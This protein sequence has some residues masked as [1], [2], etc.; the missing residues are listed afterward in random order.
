MR[1]KEYSCNR[2]SKSFRKYLLQ[3]IP[4]VIKNKIGIELGIINISVSKDLRYVTIYFMNLIENDDVFY[5]Q[6]I[7]LLKKEIAKSTKMRFIPNIEIKKY[8][9]NFMIAEQNYDD[10]C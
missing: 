5:A 2:R 6:I 9:K 10:F 7:Q 8:N 1:D 4:Y 3:F